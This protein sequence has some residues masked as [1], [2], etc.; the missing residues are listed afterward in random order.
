MTNIRLKCPVCWET[1]DWLY[2]C[3]GCA[4]G[5]GGCHNVT[6]YGPRRVPR[7]CHKCFTRTYMPQHVPK[8]SREGVGWKDTVE[9]PAWRGAEGKIEKWAVDWLR[10]WLGEGYWFWPGG[11]TKSGS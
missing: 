4:K 11:Q 10:T 7:M 1:V 9:N 3:E 6:W 5:R 2:G 8:I